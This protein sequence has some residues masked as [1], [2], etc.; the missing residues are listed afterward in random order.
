MEQSTSTRL[1]VAEDFGSKYTE[2][3]II[4]DSMIAGYFRAVQ[5]LVKKIPANDLHSALEIGCGEGYSTKKLQ[6]FMPKHVL[7]EAS[8]YLERQVVVANQM[9]PD[10]R[11]IQED[12]HKLQRQD[13]SLDLLFL[14]EVLEHL[15]EFPK[16]LNELHRVSKRFVIIGVP[17][18]PWWR[19]LNMIR[20]KYWRGLG[21]TPGH[22][23]HFNPISMRKLLAKH[24]FRV[25]A[26]KL[27]VPWM[28]TLA[29]KVDSGH[30]SA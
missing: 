29:E 22:V 11:I 3:N 1:P 12:V 18:E 19:I 17:H 6:S 16:A 9:I 25:V 14:L 26:M 15:P 21:N 23:N 20:G 5:D 24:G 10:M 4:F 8:E 30:S 27:P 28:V 13:S 2:S 7:M